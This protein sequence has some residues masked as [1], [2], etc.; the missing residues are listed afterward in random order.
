MRK[1]P[2]RHLNSGRI[3]GKPLRK[4]IIYHHTNPEIRKKIYKEGFNP[5]GKTLHKL[6]GTSIFS[7]KTISK[8]KVF[9]STYKDFWWLNDKPIAIKLTKDSKI[10]HRS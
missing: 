7:P 8:R 4:E 2:Y 5:T 3:S 6:S 9:G 10:Q 1:L